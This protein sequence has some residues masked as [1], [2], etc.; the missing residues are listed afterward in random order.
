M[1]NNRWFNGTWDP[2]TDISPHQTDLATQLR[3]PLLTSAHPKYF[4]VTGIIVDDWLWHGEVPTDEEVEVIGAI[5]KDYQDYFFP[6]PNHFR[7]QMEA[8]A[9]YDIDGGANG[10]LFLKRGDDNWAY[11][12]RTWSSGP[13]LVPSY[14]QP[15]MTLEE[16]IDAGRLR[17]E[18]RT[19]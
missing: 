10:F 13:S 12:R 14:D 16:V 5:R 4:Y 11:N 18:R 7:T 3:V 6:E 15:P 1:P 2:G 8:F 9:P 17:L 19:S